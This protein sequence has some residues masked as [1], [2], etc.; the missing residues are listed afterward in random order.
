MNIP[1]ALA[2]L[3]AAGITPAVL[4]EER[5]DPTDAEALLGL[6]DAEIRA[7]TDGDAIADQSQLDALFAAREALLPDGERVWRESFAARLAADLEE[8]YLPDAEMP[9]CSRAA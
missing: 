2:H 1:A 9:A 5:I 4:A 3:A 7:V 8:L 6:V